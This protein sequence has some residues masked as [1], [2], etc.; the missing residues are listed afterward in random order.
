MGAT[1]RKKLEKAWRE[2]H[3]WPER[4]HVH[5]NRFVIPDFSESFKCDRCE[6]RFAWRASYWIDRDD[7]PHDRNADQVY[8]VDCVIAVW[9]EFNNHG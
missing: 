3:P 9:E 8:C 5:G 4:I 1:E 6:E 2:A 7:E